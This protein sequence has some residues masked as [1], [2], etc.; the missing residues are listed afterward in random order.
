MADLIDFH[1][2]LS[3]SNTNKNIT[4]LKKIIALGK[5]GILQINGQLPN[6]AY[7]LQ[8]YIFSKGT[9]T[10]DFS[11][12]DLQ[13][14][15][16]FERWL[17]DPHM[18]DNTESYFHDV[19]ANDFRG[20]TSE[21]KLSFW[22]RL[23]NY[24]FF[25]RASLS[26]SI[27]PIELTTKNQLRNMYCNFGE[28]GFLVGFDFLNLRDLVNFQKDTDI[29]RINDQPNSKRI[30]ITPQIIDVLTKINIDEFDAVSVLKQKHPLA[31]SVPENKKLERQ[32]LMDDYRSTHLYAF[33]NTWYRRLWDWILSWLG[34]NHT[35]QKSNV[36]D[37]ATQRIFNTSVL[38]SEDED[39]HKISI[40]YDSNSGLIQVVEECEPIDSA[41]YSGGG[42]KIFAH[43]GAQAALEDHSIRCKNFAGSSAGAIMAL[44]GY[45]GYSSSEC[46]EF[47][48]SVNKDVLIHYDI[49]WD[50]LS[51]PRAL[52]AALDYG[53]NKKVLNIIQENQLMDSE[54]GRA[55][56]DREVLINGVISFQ[57]LQ[58]LKN[59]FPDCG[60]KK[61]LK[62]T[63]T[64]KTKNK[65]VVFDL[66]STPLME[67]S[68][69]VKIS[70][71]I[72]PVYK[73]T[74]IDGEAHT[75]GGALR[76]FPI[77]FF[78]D[79]RKTLLSSQYGTHLGSIGFCFDH[80]VEQ[81]LMNNFRIPIYKESA[82][83][84]FI[85]SVL[86]G[87]NDPASGWAQD[88][89]KLVQNSHQVVILPANVASTDFSIAPAKQQEL[90]LSGYTATAEHLKPIYNCKS[91]SI[92]QQMH[93]IYSSVE[94]L[95]VHC[96]IR[97]KKALFSTL[98]PF[99]LQH[100]V[101]EE[102][103]EELEKYLVFH[104]EEREESAAVSSGAKTPNKKHALINVHYIVS[105]MRV[106]DA[107][108]PIF[109]LIKPRYFA[110]DSDYSKFKKARHYMNPLTYE[111]ALQELVALKGSQ[112]LIITLLKYA[113]EEY[114]S[115]VAYR[116]DKLDALS[117]E[118][119]KKEHL[120]TKSDWF[121]DWILEKTQIKHVMQLMTK[122]DFDRC[123]SWMQKYQREQA[124]LKLS[125]SYSPLNSQ[126]GSLKN[127]HHE[128][129]PF[130]TIC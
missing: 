108:Y 63:A 5:F 15:V 67:V 118:L 20:Y 100:D 121:F 88:R 70:A 68:Q 72:P 39:A 95:M 82:L 22:G 32:N 51:D 126:Q 99:A 56:I 114:S 54:S 12:L 33:P 103:L 86:T 128:K 64:N 105:H 61:S 45:L 115:N 6:D 7:R 55:F 3:K 87:V 130:V 21:T 96:A 125:L 57:S 66:D 74:L 31:I 28:N 129:V 59:R 53:I 17:F 75:D 35:Q 65:T 13:T 85:Y 19:Y 18:N 119:H 107:L 47:F 124:V 42:G 80:G 23:L 43:V 78:R 50:G 62:V 94:E 24:F 14:R 123:I 48:Q 16:K 8:D 101:L 116:C 29:E 127:S 40:K 104:S 52:K 93:A 37:T 92:D 4:L 36:V 117:K 76:N 1:T 110:S 26:W 120:L 69:A 9:F 34:F 102:R 106:F 97:G 60:I 38:S 81:S 98:K 49:D 30:K 71:S 27:T 90:L 113:M 73:H 109:L 77:E 2:L 83:I 89:I 79:S 84:N 122:G 58:N 44:L 112:H 111:S 10:V 41:V 11:A 25:R 91:K 46:K